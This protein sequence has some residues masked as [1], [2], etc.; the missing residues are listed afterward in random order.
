MRSQL[1]AILVLFA[2]A[3]TP[4]GPQATFS[5]GGDAENAVCITKLA[6]FGQQVQSFDGPPDDGTGSGIG[7]RMG[8]TW[9]VQVREEGPSLEFP[10]MPA[11]TPGQVTA[12]QSAYTYQVMVDQDNVSTILPDDDSNK[13]KITGEG[14]G[15]CAGTF[16]HIGPDGTSMVILK[17][18]S[19]AGGNITGQGLAMVVNRPQ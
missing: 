6:V 15:R 13:T 2:A 11:C 7:C 8:G 5:A 19:D 10:G 12:L 17:P 14:G 9:N 18:F 16:E 4:D 3:C 1:F